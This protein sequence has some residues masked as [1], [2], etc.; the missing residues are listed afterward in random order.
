MSTWSHHCLFIYSLAHYNFSTSNP[1][2]LLY[3][4]RNAKHTL[5]ALFYSLCSIWDYQPSKS[6]PITLRAPSSRI[7]YILFCHS[8][9]SFFI[10][11]F[12]SLYP[13]TAGV[14]K[15]LPFQHTLQHSKAKPSTPMISTSIC[16]M[17]ILTNILNLQ[18]S[19]ASYQ[20]LPHPFTW[21]SHRA[22]QI[23]HVPNWSWTF[24]P[25]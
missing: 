12:S 17:M 24:L 20:C 8:F 18:P 21:M 19:V 2:V 13:L 3:R 23:Q 14:L 10:N 1:S 7:F 25:T 11:S 5:W 4:L 22:F 16:I 9:S 15:F 6:L